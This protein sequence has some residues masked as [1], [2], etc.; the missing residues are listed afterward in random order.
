VVDDD[1][2]LS[3]PAIAEYARVH[4]IETADED[5]STVRA[6]TAKGEH[7]YFGWSEGCEKLKNW[8]KPIPDTDIRTTGGY[9]VAP[10]SIH[11][12][13]GEPYTW[14]ISPDNGNLR[15]FPSWLVDL[16]LEAK[17]K[18][19]TEKLEKIT[20]AATQ[21]KVARLKADEG[22]PYGKAALE[23]EISELRAASEGERNDRLN[24]AAFSLFGLVKG[25]ALD[26]GEVERE[27]A[28]VARSLGLKDPEI[29]KTLS[30]AWTGAAAREIPDDD[31]RTGETEARELLEI[32]ETKLVEDPEGW[33]QD[34]DVKRFLA[35]Y[36][37]RDAVGAEALLKRAGVRGALKAALMTDL[38]RIDSDEGDDEKSGRGPSMATRIVNLALAS[39]AEF[40]KT[41]EGEPFAT[42]PNEAGHK[43]NHPLKSKAAKTWLSGLLFKAE[44][45]APKGSAVADALAVLE[46]KATF[47][48][49]M[50][51]VFV[52]LAEH[53]GRFYL[54][55]GGDDWRAVEIGPD[56]W[57]VIPSEAVPVKFRRSKGILELPEPKSGGNLEI[58]RRVLNIPEGAPW[59]LV[60]AWLVQAFKPT[61]P[62]PPLIVDGEQGSGK[63]WLGRI[64]RYLIDP[65]KAALR[66]PPRNEHELMIGATNSWLVA[67]DNLSGLP[68]WLNDALCVVSTGGGM[69]TRELYTDS[70]EAL[71]D[72]QRPIIL[73]G[74]DALNAKGDLLGRAILLHLPRIE[75][76]ARRTEKEIKAELDRIRPGVLGAILDVI[77]HGLKELPNVRLE[78]M[79]RMADFAEWVVACAGA[80]GWEK[81]EFLAAF[82]ENQNESKAALIENDLFALS[83]VEF[84][85]GPEEPVVFEGTAGFLLSILEARSN[86]TG[87]NMPAGWPKTAKGTGNKLRRI[88]PALRAVG[89]E[90]E[91]LDRAHGGVRKIKIWR[92]GDD[93]KNDNVTK[94]P[95]GSDPGGQQKR[96]GKR[97]I[98]TIVTKKPAAGDD[99][100]DGDDGSL[101][102][103][104]DEEIEKRERGEREGEKKE[105][106]EREG[107]VTKS[108]SPQSPPSHDNG[109]VVTIG[110]D[111]DDSEELAGDSEPSDD[112]QSIAEGLEEAARREAAYLEKFKTPEPKAKGR[113]LERLYD[114]PRYAKNY[115]ILY[116]PAG[117]ALEYSPWAANVAKSCSHGCEYCYAPAVARKTGDKYRD[118]PD[119]KTDLIKRINA[120]LTRALEDGCNI[121][122]VHLTFAG[123]FYDPRAMEGSEEFSSSEEMTRAVIEAIHSHGVGVQILTKGRE[124]ARDFDLL[125]P[126]DRFGVSLT[127][128]DPEK[129]KEWEPGAALPDERIENLRG[130][131]EKGLTTWV[132]LEPVID[133]AATLELVR[134]SAEYV[135][136]FAVGKWNHD[137]RADSIDWHKF[138]ADVVKLL[139]SL[140]CDYYIKD[141]LKRYLPSERSETKK[142][143]E[144]STTKNDLSEEGG[145][146]R[147]FNLSQ[148]YWR[149]LAKQHHGLNTR[150]L[151]AELG[152]DDLKAGMCL[153]LL[154]KSGW[155]TDY[156]ERLQPP[157][158]NDDEEEVAA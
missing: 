131:K 121:P 129:S 95:E 58:L 82:E 141:D 69:S 39:G 42:I 53:G 64:L 86:I 28:R 132:S 37:K 3:K 76:G 73:N 96:E 48:G 19:R 10:P 154:R 137:K 89:I 62:Y 67:Y 68:G 61:G 6:G 40:W 43:E 112:Y 100:D 124:A 139:E 65:N 70:E 106:G 84:I 20:T 133:P 80:L 41:T 72:I 22:H 145:D 47:E 71:F 57:G 98:V 54:D 12:D 30:S 119:P 109:F 31:R 114:V 51:P 4:G 56:G 88:I 123:D 135:D 144:R 27:L 115:G 14:I 153:D 143:V 78:S 18:K 29:E 138:A 2:P 25:G 87:G 146:G 79:P 113:R 15:P 8:T 32:L 50:F 17:A 104:L 99:G 35:S 157:G 92:C 101:I 127:F 94:K 125:G 45:K 136:I 105:G 24:K 128:L 156:L 151:K 26:R 34:P 93:C 85:N 103:T 9:V 149:D 140:G 110:D 21:Q 91:F 120:G 75:D 66:R 155:I 63:S 97:S 108:P 90:V 23:S 7:L 83:L 5:L 77:S 147:I 102:S 107:K 122:R 130:A 81:G 52:R 126:R 1:G 16:L 74:I 38:K 46:G 116:Q 49:E 150:V 36:R 142:V 59:V 152:Y 33:A 111:G 148:P 13:T 55:L 134:R 44:G 118:V 158:Y 117:K 11:P 60:R